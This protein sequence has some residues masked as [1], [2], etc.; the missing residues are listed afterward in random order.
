MGVRYQHSA[1]SYADYRL[2]CV[3]PFEGAKSLS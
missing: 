1:N 3:L 2:V